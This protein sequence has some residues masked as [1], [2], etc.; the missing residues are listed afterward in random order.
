MLKFN[1]KLSALSLTIGLLVACADSAQVNQEAAA[2]YAQVVQEAKVKG[3][4][5]TSSATSQRI[6][7]V[8]RTMVPYATKENL[9]GQRFNWQIAV[10]KSKELNAWA[11]PGGKMMFYTGLVD[12]LKLTDDEI[13][14][15]MGHEMAH[16]LKEHGK[17][18]RNVGLF[19]G[20]I[21]V[22]ADIAASAALG[23]NT[24]L[25]SSVADLGVNKPFSRSN[26]TEADEVGLFLMA[27]SGYNPQSAPHLWE[28]MQ[29]M[30][31]GGGIS[32][33]STH[34]SDES[35]QA[36]LQRLMPDALKVYHAR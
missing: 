3:M 18:S 5:D 25:G 21:G 30:G 9:T 7:N 35:R 1:K 17:Q 32:L 19:T 28:K 12:T 26:E 20:I 23:V 14:V 15:V 8:F 2:S 34:P 22:A 24:R 31:G 4:L 6:Q 29:K 13:A 16:A 27:R 36:N 10:V 11:M 33:L